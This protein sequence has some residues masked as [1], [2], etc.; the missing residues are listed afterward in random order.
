MY[1]K[2]ILNELD[3]LNVKPLEM[4]PI[5]LLVGSFSIFLVHFL[6]PHNFLG[7]FNDQLIYFEHLEHRAVL[8]KSWDMSLI[9]YQ[10]LS[11]YI[12][13]GFTE[14][15][16][17]LSA[18]FLIFMSFKKTNKSNLF[19][20]VVLSAAFFAFIENIHYLERYG[21]QVVLTRCIFSTTTHI[22]LGMILAYFMIFSISRK[23]MSNTI[24]IMIFGLILASFLHGSFNISL[25]LELPTINIL[26]WITTLSLGILSIE[27]VKKFLS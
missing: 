24:L 12:F 19:F 6:T 2:Y 14:E 13:T 27:R 7:Y 22:C 10:I 3:D 9:N 20:Y 21:S 18:G 16:S 26:V 17:K 25:H 11:N 1:L 8:I 5:G 15:I 23:K 4:L